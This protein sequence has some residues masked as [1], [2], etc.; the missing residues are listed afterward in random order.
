MEQVMGE[1][2]VFAWWVHV[3]Q[4]GEDRLSPGATDVRLRNQKIAFEVVIGDC[5]GV[6]DGHVD[7]CEDKIFGEFCIGSIG[8]SDENSWSKQPR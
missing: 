5:F 1:A 4:S 3:L 2:F 6:V 7:S 8:R